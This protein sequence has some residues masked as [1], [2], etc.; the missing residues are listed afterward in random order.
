M[1][2]SAAMTS[3]RLYENDITDFLEAGKRGPMLVMPAMLCLPAAAM[4]ATEK[5]PAA[6]PTGKVEA[7][8]KEKCGR[9][10]RQGR[11][12]KGTNEDGGGS[13]A[14]AG[15]DGSSAKAADGGTSEV[16]CHGCSKKGHW[17]ID[18]TEELCSRCHGRGHADN[19]CP[20]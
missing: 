1:T 16:R 20:T 3:P 4:V 2:V 11:G 17:R 12:D 18:C 8:E 9:R 7:A 15:G 10:G 5:G 19:V 13:A 6:V 14:A